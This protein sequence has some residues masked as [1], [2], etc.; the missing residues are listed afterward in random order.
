LQLRSARIVAQGIPAGWSHRPRRRQPQLWKGW[1]RRKRWQ[2]LRRGSRPDLEPRL[3]DRQGAV[4][5]TELTAEVQRASIA[6]I[7]AGPVGCPTLRR[8][9]GWGHPYRAARIQYSRSVGSP[10]PERSIWFRACSENPK[11]AVQNWTVRSSR[12]VTIST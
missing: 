11:T 2:L 5:I 10:K 9:V 1:H 12:S 4:I 8:R 7:A 6:L 3:P